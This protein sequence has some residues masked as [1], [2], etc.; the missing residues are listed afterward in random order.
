MS[1]NFSRISRKIV[2]F[3]YL[4]KLW[5]STHFFQKFLQWFLSSK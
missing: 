2:C 1:T 5:C 4:K 3:I